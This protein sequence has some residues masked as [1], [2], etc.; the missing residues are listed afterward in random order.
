MNKLF[1][2]PW[3]YNSIPLLVWFLLLVLPIISVPVNIPLSY[4]HQFITHVLISNLLLLI[5]FYLHTYV[6]YPVLKQ[7]GVLWYLL[8]I[9]ILFLVY[10]SYEFFFTLGPPP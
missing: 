1:L 9:A 4:H 6:M 7:R 2:K 5:I 3:M 8:G 10:C